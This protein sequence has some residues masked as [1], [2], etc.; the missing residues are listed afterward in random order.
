MSNRSLETY[1][2]DTITN[3]SPSPFAWNGR[4]YVRKYRVTIEEVDEPHEV[5][6]ERLVDLWTRQ[7]ELKISHPGLRDAMLKEAERLGV[8]L[9]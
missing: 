9:P 3:R 5:L 1:S 6:A 4:C 2:P 7:R 8:T